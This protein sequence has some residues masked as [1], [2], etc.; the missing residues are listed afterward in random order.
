M[1]LA[2]FLEK[3]LIYFQFLFQ[4]LKHVEFST[5]SIFLFNDRFSVE[6][7]RYTGQYIGLNRLN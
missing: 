3:F 6:P 7:D 2:I 4:I 1:H 5:G